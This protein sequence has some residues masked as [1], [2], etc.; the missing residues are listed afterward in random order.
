MKAQTI[1]SLY[2]I[3]D[4]LELSNKILLEENKFYVKT[5][6]RLRSDQIVQWFIIIAQFISIIALIIIF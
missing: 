2:N 6:K 1:K 4:S 5:C 3:I